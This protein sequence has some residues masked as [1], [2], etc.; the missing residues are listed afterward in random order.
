MNVL[1]TVQLVAKT[2]RSDQAWQT[3]CGPL[4]S[5]LDAWSETLCRKHGTATS[6]HPGQLTDVLEGCHALRRN[7][8]LSLGRQRLEALQELLQQALPLLTIPVPS[9]SLKWK[10]EPLNF[11]S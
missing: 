6:Y 2:E 1:I 10:V 4:V 11:L 3:Q 9:C 7:L 5:V 8:V